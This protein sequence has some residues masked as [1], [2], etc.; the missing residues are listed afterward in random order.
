MCKASK[1]KRYYWYLRYHIGN[2]NVTNVIKVNWPLTWHE[3]F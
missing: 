3:E 2:I 1:I